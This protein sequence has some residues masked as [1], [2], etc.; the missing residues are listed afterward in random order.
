[1]KKIALILALLGLNLAIANDDMNDNGLNEDNTQYEDTYNNT[2]N[3]TDETDKNVLNNDNMQSDDANANDNVDEYNDNSTIDENNEADMSNDVSN[4]DGTQIQEDDN[5]DT[6]E[7]KT[8]ITRWNYTEEEL[9]AKKAKAEKKM[10]EEKEAYE[11]SITRRR[12]GMFLGGGMGYSGTGIKALADT[13][14]GN[15]NVN[16]IGLGIFLGYQDAF[17]EYAGVRIYGEFDYNLGTGIFY[18][19]V[20]NGDTLRMDGNIM[21]G[22]GNV[23]F[24]LEGDMGRNGTETLGAFLGLGAGYMY[25]AGNADNNKVQSVLMAINAGVH[26]II[27]DNNRIEVFLRWYPFIKGVKATNKTEVSGTSDVW[28]R[29]SYI[30]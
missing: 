8:D 28:L 11:L 26:T 6:Q 7:D 9:A 17:N 22:L 12:S 10:Q 4:D 1:M 18:A 27:G 21:K 24:Y 20:Q 2:D 30:F 3:N 19:N 15:S 14:T 16:G 29:Y 13:V 25:Y 5:K 23:D